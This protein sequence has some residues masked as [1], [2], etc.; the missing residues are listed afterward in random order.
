MPTLEYE[1]G[2]MARRINRL[3]R[4]LIAARDK[5]KLYRNEHSGE[6]VGGVEYTTLMEEINVALATQQ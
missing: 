3:E 5:L 1:R 6:Y 4:A 2:E